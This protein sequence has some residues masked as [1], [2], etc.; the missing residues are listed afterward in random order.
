MKQALSESGR[1]G[2]H[3]AT[4]RP[5]LTLQIGFAGSRKLPAHLRPGQPGHERLRAEVGALLRGL[6]QTL[7]LEPTVFFTGVSQLAV[8]AD[9]LFT[10]AMAELG[11]PQRIFLPQARD[12]FLAAEGSDGPDFLPQDREVVRALL[13]SA[14]VIEERVVSHA[15]TRVDRFQEANLSIVDEADV[16]ICLQVREAEGRPGGTAELMSKALARRRPVLL[17]TLRSDEG[18]GPLLELSRV[19]EPQ[20]AHLSFPSVL[21]NGPAFPAATPDPVGL[22][23]LDSYV[24]AIKASASSQAGQSRVGFQFAAGV[25]I[26]THVCAT[27]LALLALKLSHVP[28]WVI[29]VLLLMESALLWWG[30]RTHQALH[31][32]HALREWAM[33][34]LCAEVAR[35]VNSLR[36]M[37]VG[38]DHLRQMGVPPELDSL[39]KTLNVLH[40]R[41]NRSSPPADLPSLKHRYLSERLNQAS[42]GQLAYYRKEKSVAHR[43]FQMASRLFMALSILAL[44]ATLSK[45]ALMLHPPG[46]WAVWKSVA[47]PA[48]ILLPVVAVGIMSLATAMDWEARAH[49]F[50]DM[51]HFVAR[52]AALVEM[53]S[54]LREFTSLVLQTEA[55]LLAETLSW[56]GRRSYVGVA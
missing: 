42:S 25:V 32:E 39:N 23:G 18:E 50:D 36:G 11:W 24:K 41:D 55:R 27:L 14:H 22:P 56:F 44:L 49:S 15:N 54:S 35:S 6:H 29:G 37:P 17:L 12:E 28:E 40:L 16:L 53:A 5:P 47:G 20:A 10:Q 21:L 51:Q 9:T 52:Q 34:R 2:G 19:G 31:N 38:L 43:R 26:G 3:P 45:L 46:D 13:D 8:G 1:H 48:A 7:S 4:P 30:Y 33:A